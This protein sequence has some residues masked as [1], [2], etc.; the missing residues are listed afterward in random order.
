MSTPRAGPTRPT[1]PLEPRTLSAKPGIN[2]I[3]LLPK[4]EY[5][6]LIVFLSPRAFS[7]FDPHS[8]PL[9]A[10]SS[11]FS[12]LSLEAAQAWIMPTALIG[13]V[14]YLVALCVY[15]VTLHPLAP[16]PGPL[17]PAMTFWC[18]LYHD[19]VYGGQYIYRIKDMHAKYGPIVRISPDEL[20]VN[21]PSFLPQLMPSGKHPRDK[22]PR[23]IRVFGFSQAAG[24]TADHELHRTRR[25]A[26][27][28]MFS[29]ESVRRLEPIMRRT[30]DRLL[31]RLKG[32]QESGDEINLKSMYGA[33]TND[34]ITEYAY[35]FSTNWT[36][37]PKFN[38]IFFHMV[39]GR[40]SVDVR[41]NTYIRNSLTAFMILGHLRCSSAGLCHWFICFPNGSW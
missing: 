19:A 28:K 16:F 31:L 10:T 11:P 41:Q 6:K 32:F 5:M 13:Y 7:I 25:A 34:V 29:K 38:E 17:L 40:S 3:L 27:S 22:Y 15:R 36:E 18:E 8:H 4:P 21:D 9:Y 23:L 35:G 12:M 24:A 33:F 20:H 26:M 39:S 2:G 14:L 1:S 30:L 37:A